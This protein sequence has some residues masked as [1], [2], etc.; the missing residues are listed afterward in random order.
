MLLNALN[1]HTIAA[2]ASPVGIAGVGVLRLSGP[3]SL[4]ILKRIFRSKKFVSPIQPNYVYVG[5]VFDPNDETV[6]DQCCAVYFKGPKSFTGEDVVEIQCHSSP[7]LLKRLLELLLSQGASLAD[8]GEFSK[9][10]F[11]NG[12]CDL[13]QAESLIDLIHA[14]SK[15]QHH[16][17][18]NQVQGK[19]FKHITAIRNDLKSVLEQI[20][21]SIDFPE[22]VPD[23]NRAQT[24]ALLCDIQAKLHHILNLQ[25]YGKLISGGIHCLCVGKPNAGK[26]SLFNALINEDRSI[27]SNIP[28]TTRDYI[29]ESISYQGYLFQLYDTAGL[30]DSDDII[31]YMGMKKIHELIQKA[32]IILFVID[33]SEPLNDNDF[34]VYEAI[35]DNS[36]VAIIL[37]KSDLKQ[38]VTDEQLSPFSPLFTL[39]CSVFDTGAIEQLKEALYTHSVEGLNENDLE[40]ICNVRQLACVRKLNEQVKQVLHGLNEALDDD[41]LSLDLRASVEC[42]S[43]LVGDAL[44]EELLD[45]I[46]SRFCVGK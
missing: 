13:T 14:E 23:I 32:T 29:S 36:N 18:L 41:L 38:V 5:E 16:V 35:K 25:D 6:L 12:K 3:D 24:K 44:T 45:G 20:E 1:T 33:A 2:I 34:S 43:E 26:S 22:E 21:G 10:A 37:M 28:G 9:R 7:Y 31:E 8:K 15:Q 40:Y 42:C 17:S 11:V 4:A 27:V 19:L 30:R 46:F 39:S